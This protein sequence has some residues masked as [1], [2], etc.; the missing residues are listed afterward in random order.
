MKSERLLALLLLLQ[1][2]GRMSAA[3]LASRL[4]VTERTIHRDI[5][6]LSLAG[7]PV[8][9]ERGRHGGCA[10]LPGYRTDVSGLTGEE[11]KALF[12]FAG[13]GTVADLGLEPHLRGGLR[14]LMAALPEVSRAGAAQ[15]QE[16][17]VVDPRGWLRAPEEIPHLAVAQAAVWSGRRLRLRYRASGASEATERI[18]D[19]Y[20]LVAKAGTWYLIAA[21]EG[22]PRL[23]RISRLEGAV[24]LAEQ[25]LRPPDLDLEALWDTLRRRVEDRGEGVE[26]RLRIKPERL[27]LML[28]LTAAQ[29]IGGER[30]VQPEADSQGWRLVTARFVS[31][32][33]CAGTL[34]GFGADVEILSPPSLRR[35]FFF[36]FIAVVE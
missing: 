29:T 18:V 31:E 6:S 22:E 27:E 20:G 5:E 11:A 15:A 7:V 14:K 13:R 19:P 35:S 23:Y 26:V 33:A 1:A 3:Q 32:G 9:T 36:Y 21:Q 4:E 2:H 28:R 10:L 30:Q 24:E 17:V 25:A 8:Y 34:L 12:I 16:R